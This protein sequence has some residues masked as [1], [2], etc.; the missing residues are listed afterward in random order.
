MHRPEEP[1]FSTGSDSDTRR[2]SR[3]LSS[4]LGCGC[5]GAGAAS[6]LR[7]PP[8]AAMDVPRGRQSA[9]LPALL[10]ALEALALHLE[11][12]PAVGPFYCLRRTNFS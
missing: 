3:Q 10:A 6:A 4:L 5:I 8:S 12:E 11:R 1:P 2:L 9:H 7:R